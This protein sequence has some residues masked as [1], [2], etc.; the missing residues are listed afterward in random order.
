MCKYV[1][2]IDKAS[3]Y[4]NEYVSV[5]ASFVPMKKSLLDELPMSV[6]EDFELY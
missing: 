3:L 2:L 5:D 6:S 1:D 4:I